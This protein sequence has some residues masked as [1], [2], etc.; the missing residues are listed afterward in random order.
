MIHYHG[1]PVGGSR[2]DVARFLMGRHAC[3]A[4]ARPDDLAVVMDV[5]DSPG[6]WCPTNGE[7]VRLL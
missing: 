3:V 1:T 2:Q 5:C 6:V 7:Q 4:F